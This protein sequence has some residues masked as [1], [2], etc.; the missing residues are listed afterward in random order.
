MEE[1]VTRTVEF[2]MRLRKRKHL[3]EGSPSLPAP[4]CRRYSKACLVCLGRCAKEALELRSGQIY[5]AFKTANREVT[6]QSPPQHAGLR[7][8]LLWNRERPQAV[9][10]EKPR[11]SQYR[12]GLRPEHVVDGES[13]GHGGVVAGV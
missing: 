2:R 3:G 10:G 6:L 11:G 12:G 4:P 13:S 1:R 8:R 5:G 9:V 7:A